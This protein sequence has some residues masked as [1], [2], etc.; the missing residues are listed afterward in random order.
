MA[1][2]CTSQFACICIYSLHIFTYFYIIACTCIL[3]AYKCIFLHIVRLHIGACIV[4]I[5]CI[6]LHIWCICLHTICTCAYFCIQHA[7]FC[8]LISAYTLCISTCGKNISVHSWAAKG[9]WTPRLCAANR[10]GRVLGRACARARTGQ[11]D[12]SRL[13][14]LISA[15]TLAR[16]RAPAHMLMHS[17]AR[18]HANTHTCSSWGGAPNLRISCCNCVFLFFSSPTSTYLTDSKIKVKFLFVCMYVCIYS[19]R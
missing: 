6:Y 1:Y 7:H 16:T 4:H 11:G 13:S 18:T 10:A 12:A 8:L 15:R 2:I 5:G 19:R 17:R 9:R 3:K 14:G